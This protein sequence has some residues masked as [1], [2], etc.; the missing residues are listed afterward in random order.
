MFGKQTRFDVLQT[1][2][3]VQPSKELRRHEPEEEKSGSSSCSYRHTSLRRLT[4]VTDTP[5]L[6]W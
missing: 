6:P 2:S 4:T 5:L 3:S 1:A